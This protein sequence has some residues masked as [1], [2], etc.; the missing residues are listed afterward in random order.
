MLSIRP[1]H[2]GLVATAVILVVGFPWLGHDTFLWAAAAAAAGL[3][4]SRRDWRA[5]TLAAAIVAPGLVWSWMD[6]TGCSAWWRGTIVTKKLAGRL[7]Y[8][9]W[10]AVRRTALGTCSQV[11]SRGSE[12]DESV[13]LLDEKKEA[14]YGLEL[15]ETALGRF[16][17]PSLGREILSFIT[18]EL[19][20]QE[21]YSSSSVRV[22][23]GDT[24]IDVGAHVGVFA[25]Y[26]LRQG[27]DRVIA[28]EPEP[29]NIACLQANFEREISEGRVRLIEGGLWHEHGTLTL[30]IAN[31]NSGGH[32][33]VMEERQYTSSVEVPV[34]PL[35]EVVE[36]LGLER[37][38]FIKM[39]IEGSERHALRGASQT[40]KRF[41]PR[42]AIC[43]YHTPDDPVVVPSVVRGIE[44]SYRIHAKD[45]ELVIRWIVVK[46]LFFQ[47]AD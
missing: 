41:R 39:D 45:V 31:D 46:V 15:Y 3:L 47:T 34:F 30:R 7:P 21:T 6:V 24:V 1:H 19:A 16:W 27:A 17:V 9:D 23:P 11:L 28:I 43:I 22:R 35:D 4:G 37:V 26:A 32:S 2:F 29:K 12:W 13:R 40:L 42:M 5:W 25:R 20:V 14:Q 44:P 8:L 36:E 10:L 18:W 38:D 33:F